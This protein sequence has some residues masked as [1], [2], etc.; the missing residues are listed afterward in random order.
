MVNLLEFVIDNLYF[1]SGW[2]LGSFEK[3]NF[4]TIGF[5]VVFYWL[6]DFKRRLAGVDF[7]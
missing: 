2:D 7:R 4:G 5:A 1:L 3:K 6:S